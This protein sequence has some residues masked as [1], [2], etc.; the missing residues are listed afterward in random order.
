MVDWRDMFWVD[1]DDPNRF[2]WERYFRT[3]EETPREGLA[4]YG[5]GTGYGGLRRGCEIYEGKETCAEE[6]ITMA[7]DYDQWFQNEIARMGHE[8]LA[9]SDQPEKIGG[10]VYKGAQQSDQWGKTHVFQRQITLTSSDLYRNYPATETLKFDVEMLRRVEWERTV[11]DGDKAV[12]HS[13]Y[14]LVVWKTLDR[15]EV[16][17]GLFEIKP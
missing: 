8:A 15:S 17:P 10:Y 14:R 3:R 1:M 7:L 11:I 12:L 2:R 9:N 5:I 6:P 16:P 4:Y 13:R